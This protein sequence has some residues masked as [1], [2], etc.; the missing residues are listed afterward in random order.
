[1]YIFFL[2]V[3]FNC[4]LHDLKEFGQR[5]HNVRM[6]N[7]TEDARSKTQTAINGRRG[8]SRVSDTCTWVEHLKRSHGLTYEQCTTL[9]RNIRRLNSFNCSSYGMWRIYY[10]NY[11]WLQDL[12]YHFVCIPMLSIHASTWVHMKVSLFL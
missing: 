9:S 3:N 7:V 5:C 1:M 12:F 8:H 2:Q 6:F 10:Y 11:L 4:T